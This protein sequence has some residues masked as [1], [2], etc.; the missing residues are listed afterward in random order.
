[1]AIAGWVSKLKALGPSDRFRSRVSE[2]FCK[3][4]DAVC[5]FC[6]PE[7][8]FTHVARDDSKCGSIAPSVGEICCPFSNLS[9]SLGVSQDKMKN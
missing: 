4:A 8:D 7:I 2:L 1:M 3:K 5:T 6:I 9:V